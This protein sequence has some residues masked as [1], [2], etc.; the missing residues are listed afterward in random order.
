M[1]C[2]AGEIFIVLEN[3]SKPVGVGETLKAAEEI[4]DTMQLYGNFNNSY[5]IVPSELWKEN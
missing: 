3:D 4:R 1:I 2:N 5:K